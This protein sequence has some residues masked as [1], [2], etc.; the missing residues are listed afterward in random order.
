ML[1]YAPSL[2]SSG[3]QQV[4]TAERM[5]NVVCDESQLLIKM[6][7]KRRHCSHKQIG[8]Q[9]RLEYPESSEYIK[10]DRTLIWGG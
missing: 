4:E 1:F 2:T 8:L 6:L 9:R 10:F 7:I 3:W 5:R